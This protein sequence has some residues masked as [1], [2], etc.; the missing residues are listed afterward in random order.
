MT[1]PQPFTI[2]IPDSVL[3]D[4]RDRLSRVRWPDQVPGG[5]W[6]YGT[7]LSYLQELVAYW[8]DRYDWRAAEAKLNSFKQYKLPITGIDLHFIHE[9][10]KGPNPLPLLISHGWPGSVLEFERLIPMLT[11]PAAHGGRAEDSF[12]VIAPS[13]PGYAFSF[14]P[15]QPRFGAPEIA[16]AF[17]DLMA[18]LGY[19]KYVAQGG[20]WGAFVTSSLAIQHP[21]RLHAIHLNLLPLRRDQTATQESTEAE[22]KYFGELA[23]WMREKTGY[24][25]IM[26]T[27]PQTIAYA[28]TDSPVG[29]AAWIVEKFRAWSDCGGDVE[30]CFSKDTLLTNVMLY[31]ATGAI[32]SSCWPYSARMHGPWPV[33]ERVSVPTAYAEFPCEILHP[34]RSLAEKAFNIQRWTTMPRGGHFAAREQP[35][36]LAQDLR[37]FFRAFRRD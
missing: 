4:L 36:L 25:A 29:L 13:L 15:N 10:G 34:P 23:E 14:A 16:R 8:R 19:E 5:G 17:A 11:D 20:D 24:Q 12:T 26:G 2:S 21:E 31:W 3:L 35:Q 9:L 33:R 6:T 27:R 37:D 28:L 32:N 7:D 1:A 22:R 18:A 30:T